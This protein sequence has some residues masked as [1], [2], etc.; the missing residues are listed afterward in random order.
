M[1]IPIIVG[2]P[3]GISGNKVVA[4]PAYQQMTIVEVDGFLRALTTGPH[5]V[6][7]RDPIAQTEVD[8]LTWNAAGVIQ[9]PQLEVLIPPDNGLVF[10]VTA[11]GT[12]AL[13][14][15]ITCWCWIQ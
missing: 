5:A 6:R 15:V 9:H 13:D 7:V 1:V 11:L 8:I 12:G 4:I 14:C 2:L 10:D 3:N